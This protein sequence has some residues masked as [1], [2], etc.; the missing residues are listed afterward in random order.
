VQDRNGA[1]E[2]IGWMQNCW[3]KVRKTFADGGYSGKLV[4]RI[5]KVFGIEVQNC[6]EERG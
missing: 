2:V 1:D 4:E 6:E 5:Q 3:H